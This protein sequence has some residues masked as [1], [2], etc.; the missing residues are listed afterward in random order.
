MKKLTIVISALVLVTML[1][2]ACEP[3]V[4]EKVVTEVVEVTKE[5]EKIVEVEVTKEVEKIVEVGGK[6]RDRHP[7]TAP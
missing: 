5:V 7:G 3:E 6:S 4:I 2:T 1:F